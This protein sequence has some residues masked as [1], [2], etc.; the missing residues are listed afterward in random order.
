MSHWRAYAAARAVADSDLRPALVD[1][2]ETL[3][4]VADALRGCEDM[5]EVSPTEHSILEAVEL[6]GSYAAGAKEAEDA[7]EAQQV[8]LDEHQETINER[9]ALLEMRESALEEQ[10]A[11][12]QKHNDELTEKA[13][14][15]QPML[16]AYSDL[17]ARARTFVTFA[18]KSGVKPRHVRAVD[19]TGTPKKDAA[20]T[21]RKGKKTF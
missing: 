13:I 9:V 3:H 16:D 18:E 15:A 10:V 5:G 2:L 17:L 21:R 11:M 6:L 14:A 20:S 8:A 4:V 19:G 1:V 7:A 12:L